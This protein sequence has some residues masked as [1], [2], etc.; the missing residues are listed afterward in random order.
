MII[1][2]WYSVY[3]L[4]LSYPFLFLHRL[5]SDS[6]ITIFRPL[7][8]SDTPSFQWPVA[9]CSRPIL[10]DFSY[11]W[12]VRK[13]LRIVRMSYFYEVEAKNGANVIPKRIFWGTGTQLLKTHTTRTVPETWGW[14]GT[15]DL[16]S[17]QKHSHRLFIRSVNSCRNA[18]WHTFHAGTFTPCT[19]ATTHVTYLRV[20][21]FAVSA[22]GNL[23]LSARYAEW[24]TITKA[25]F[26]LLPLF[27]ALL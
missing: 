19:P 5:I 4:F 13:F 10:V 8:P 26:T 27:S 15:L 2:P 9:V 21:Y 24:F 17:R 1:K 12:E 16:Q 20:Q 22:A 23:V 14:T 25:R 6:I 7:S 11:L 18:R 3:W